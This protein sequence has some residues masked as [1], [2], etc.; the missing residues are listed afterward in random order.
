MDKI[1]LIVA[2]LV[3]L[4]QGI[5]AYHASNL[6]WGSAAGILTKAEKRKHEK[7]FAASMLAAFVILLGYLAYALTIPNR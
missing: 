4:T 5:A 1:T 6:L 7:W 2:A 3:F